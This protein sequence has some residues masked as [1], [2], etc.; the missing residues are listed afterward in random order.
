MCVLH[1]TVKLFRVIEIEETEKID[2][3]YTELWRPAD[4]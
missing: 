4:I 2:N 3:G 1:R